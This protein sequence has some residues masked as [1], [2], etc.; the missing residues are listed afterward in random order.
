MGILTLGPIFVPL[1]FL[2]GLFGLLRGLFCRSTS[3]TGISIVGLTLSI[4]GFFFSPSLILMTGGLFL[5]SKGGGRSHSET[6]QVLD[7]NTVAQLPQFE[8][9]FCEITSSGSAKYFTWAGEAKKARDDKNGIQEKRAQDA[10]T[11]TAQFRNAEI[12]K[13]AQQTRFKFEDWGVRLLKIGSPNDKRVTFSVRP[14]CSNIVTIHITA[15]TNAALI[16]A[17]AAKREGDAFIISGTFAGGRLD[18]D[19][20]ATSPDAKRFEQSITELGSMEEP[21]FWA[22]LQ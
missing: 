13:L 10:M 12:F 8:K 19:A 4:I 1:S 7:T 9:L 2:F 5:A 17:L 14:L 22:Q 16:E 18:N 15:A 11:S 3:G 20:P 6:S 21:E